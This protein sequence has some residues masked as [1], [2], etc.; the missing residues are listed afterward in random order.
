[1]QCT[2]SYQALRCL[3]FFSLNL[4]CFRYYLRKAHGSKRW[5]VY[6]EGKPDRVHNSLTFRKETR[7]SK[8]LRRQWSVYNLVSY[9]VIILLPCDRG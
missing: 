8:H 1:M 6:L 9:T 7:R 5:I 3:S 4:F 2:W